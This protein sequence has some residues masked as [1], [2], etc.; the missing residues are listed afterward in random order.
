M[1][2]ITILDWTEF[3]QE[4]ICFDYWVEEMESTFDS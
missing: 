4:L 2:E 3:H 1:E